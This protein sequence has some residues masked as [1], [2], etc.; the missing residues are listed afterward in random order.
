[1]SSTLQRPPSTDIS[2]HACVS[3]VRFDS[4]KYLYV[5]RSF[6]RGVVPGLASD[7]TEYLKVWLDDEST[8]GLLEF[9]VQ[10]LVERDILVRFFVAMKLGRLTVL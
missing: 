2:S 8:A 5:R 6:R 4:R 1:M 10:R 9:A 3:K 7:T